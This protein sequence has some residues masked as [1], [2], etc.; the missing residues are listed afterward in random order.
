MTWNRRE[1]LG[2]LGVASAQAILWAMGC[3]TPA[4]PTLRAPETA[5]A[6]RAWLHDAVAA[7]HG[8]GLASVHALAVTRRR[9][10]AAIDVLGAGVSRGRCDGVVLT[11]HDRDGRREQV[12]S[13]LSADGV[14]AA[15]R[16]LG[17]GRPAAIDFGR[18]QISAAPP[19]PKS[20]PR[21]LTDATLRGMV[22]TMARRDQGLS[23]RIVY[24][25]ALLDVDD[26]TVWSVAPGRDLEQRVVRVRRALTRVAWNGTRPIVSETARAWAG[27]VDDQ[28]LTDAQIIAARDAAL[29]LMTPT[30][31]DD[32]EHPIVLEPS[33]VA[34]VID[35]AVR[36]LFTTAAARRPEVA[37]R[38]AIGAA[39]ASP[40][41]TLVDDPT[42]AA[43][44]GGFAFDD[45]GEP[46]AAQTL[47]ER[48]HVVG[49]LSDRAGVETSGAALAGRGRRPG[50]VGRVEPAPS[51]LRLA[52][53]AGRSDDLLD[54]GYRLEG[55][56]GAVVDPSS[57]RV[58]IS[59]ARALELR[60]GQ[61]TG[62]VY[63]DIE[64]VGELGR[65]LA[66]VA[67]ASHDTET[68]GIRDEL[69]GQPRWRSIEV[70]WLRASGLVRAR[71]RRT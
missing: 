37:R 12:T 53:G 7:L 20:D 64:L 58:V 57:D 61:P 36:A 56:L 29:V 47:L 63:A 60:G 6:V 44:Y 35:A 67:A 1:V 9:T 39:I 14:A 43:S 70:P 19:S 51:H 50:H 32:G 34:T 24:A 25:A 28:D 69:D 26:A 45:E 62:R 68:I 22:E 11:V 59:V 41:L 16:A 4:R 40:T 54:A 46:A 30:A 17:G 38:L 10:T 55:G 27:G 21:L 15:V 42:A 49:R 13:E 71:R 52:P 31:F 5:G 66:S 65:L 48:G 33:V 2:G 23:S 8:A 18:P 3:R